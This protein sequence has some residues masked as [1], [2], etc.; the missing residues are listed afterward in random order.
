MCYDLWNACAENFLSLLKKGASIQKSV[1]YDLSQSLQKFAVG[2]MVR[3]EILDCDYLPSRY[4]TIP[5]FYKPVT[6]EAPQNSNN[7]IIKIIK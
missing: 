6:C 4:G 3:S 7:A 2:P 5:C 1:L